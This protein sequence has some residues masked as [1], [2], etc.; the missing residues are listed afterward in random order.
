MKR[1]A[2]KQMDLSILRCF[3][4]FPFSLLMNLKRIYRNFMQQ[5]L[6]W[7]FNNF[8]YS[9]FSNL[10]VFRLIALQLMCS[11]SKEAIPILTHIYQFQISFSKLFFQ[12]WKELV[13]FFFDLRHNLFLIF[14]SNCF[15]K[16]VSWR[17]LFSSNMLFVFSST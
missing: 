1:V 4:L 16:V 5:S 3:S 2:S 10:L 8:L 13:F 14:F 12:V 9:F 11:R 17:I 6:S 15:A 7:V